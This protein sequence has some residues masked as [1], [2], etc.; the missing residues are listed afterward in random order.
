MASSVSAPTPRSAS[1][2]CTPRVSKLSRVSAGWSRR[3]DAYLICGTPRT[4]STLLCGLLRSTDV[5][6][7]PESYFRLPDQQ[8]WATSWQLPRDATGAFD[9]RD[10]LRAAVAAGSSRNGIF[11][12]RIMWGTLE[13]I[14]SKLAS[15][16]P[17]RAGADV[18]LLTRAFGRTHFVFLRRDDTVAQAVSWARAEQTHFW[19]D[20]DSALPSFAPRF[21]FEQIH[22]LV[23]TIEAHNAAWRTWFTA[24]GVRP[25]PVTYEHLARDPAGVTRGILD[26]LGLELTPDLL[27]E[28]GTRRQADGLNDAWINRYRA[29]QAC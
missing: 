11:A 17:D 18:E 2:P 27:I 14:V 15:V 9:Y 8:T 25:Y 22:T 10:Y 21:D 24:C 20:G 16:Y 7:R 19:Q 13:E 26:F 1:P 6:G 3:V 23:Q 28:P 12:C 5:A 29:M 4:G